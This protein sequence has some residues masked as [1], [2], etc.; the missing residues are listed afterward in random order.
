MASVVF[1]KKSQKNNGGTNKI[2]NITAANCS[3]L[4]HLVSSHS[5]CFDYIPSLEKVMRKQ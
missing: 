2:I 5:L 3:R 4:A 1:R